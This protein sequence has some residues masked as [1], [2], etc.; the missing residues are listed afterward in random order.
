MFYVSL[1]EPYYTYMGIAPPL[2]PVIIEGEPKY[3]IK[4]IM[5]D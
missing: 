1:L 4:D 3:I 5:K 2:E